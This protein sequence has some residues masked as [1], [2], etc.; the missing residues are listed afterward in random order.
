MTG[1]DERFGTARLAAQRRRHRRRRRRVAALIG[2]GIVA[3]V[4]GGWALVRSDLHRQITFGRPDP[5]IHAEGLAVPPPGAEGAAAPTDAPEPVIPASA[6]LIDLPG[7]PMRLRLAGA[8]GDG[9]GAPERIAR[10]GLPEA[11]RG[12]GDLILLRDTLIASGER[13]AVTLPSSREDF[14]IFQ[15]QRQRALAQAGDAP[16]PGADPGDP[17]RALLERPQTVAEALAL[18]DLHIRHAAQVGHLVHGGS[19][20]ALRAPSRRH[21][22]FDDAVVRV[23]A[24]A[25]LV[26]ILTAEGL[27]RPQAEAVAEAAHARFGIEGLTPG[28]LI[29][30]RTASMAASDSPEQMFAQ[31]TLYDGARYVGSLARE[32][33]GRSEAP[34]GAAPWVVETPSPGAETAGPDASADPAPLQAALRAVP[35]A[36]PWV[37]HAFAAAVPD[38]PSPQPGDVRVLDAIYSAAMRHGIEPALVGQII[39]LL[40]EAHNL[41]G[42][43]HPGDR[44]TL[45]MS[46][47]PHP[48]QDAA[49]AQVLYLGIEGREVTAGCYVFKPPGRTNYACYGRSPGTGAGA[50]VQVGP[51][52]QEMLSAGLEVETL[53]NRI[54]Q[55]ESAGRADARNPLSTAT[56]L[57]QFIES[58]WLRMMRTYR[59]ELVATRSRAELLALRVDP[60]ISREMVTNLARE[61]ESYLRARGHQITAGRLYL[62]HFL[63]ME[64]AHLVLSSP[65]HGDLQ[66]ILGAAVINANPF[67]RGN[68]VA[69]I[70]NWAERHMQRGSGRVAVIREPVGLPEFRA[71]VDAALS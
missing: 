39:M 47:S 48:D 8:N 40:S 65:L 21:G 11:T 23:T 12:A 31:I 68:D 34:G 32:A 61:G 60:A 35:G 15:A 22:L 64:G 6:A 9:R 57:G 4:A 66:A 62:A 1:A 25:Q 43:V 71:A 69:W 42:M 54:I 3:M 44:F 18:R 2:V 38:A 26:D 27:A 13:V 7:Q 63:G 56:G 41:D 29:A 30:L 55:I 5:G 53:V 45:L 49:L 46:E 51:A 14:A 10:P 52:Q 36:D 50:N 19:R 20:L 67:L 17:S 33:A 59:P 58:T 70:I 24:P 16:D 37:G 28:F